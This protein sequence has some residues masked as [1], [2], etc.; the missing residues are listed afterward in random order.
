MWIPFRKQDL[1]AKFRYPQTEQKVPAVL[2]VHGFDSTKEGD[3][4][5]LERLAEQ[6]LEH[7][8]AV[9]QVDFCSCGEHPSSKKEYGF[10][11][12]QQELMAAFTWL[13]QQPMV[14]QE[15]CGVIA[16][17]L[18][19]R[20]AA[21]VCLD[22][23]FSFMVLL[24]GA[25][26]NKYRTPWFFK[27][28][29]YRMEQECRTNGKTYMEKADGTT[30]EIYQS[31][32]IELEQSNPDD[33]LKQYQK[34]ILIMYGEKDPTVDPRVSIESYELLQCKDKTLLEI[35]MANHTFQA[36]T[37]NYTIWNQCMD[38]IMAWVNERR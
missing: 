25:L 16:H 18:G 19:A 8:F 7:G 21:T 33:Y 31:F 3:G 22:V 35:P 24:N 5:M 27:E 30:I 34:S 2:L 6:L 9:L 32:M 14:K 28:N 12:L 4:R 37:G 11:R 13:Y 26:G 17:S 10:I 1:P 20:V 36:K 38:Q 15:T 29:L 23:P